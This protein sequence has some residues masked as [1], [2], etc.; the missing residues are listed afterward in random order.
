M[1][2]DPPMTTLQHLRSLLEQASPGPWEHKGFGFRVGF[3]HGFQDDAKPEQLDSGIYNA[4]LIA[5]MHAAIPSLLAVVEAAQA[6]IDVTDSSYEDHDGSAYRRREAVGDAEREL[7]RALDAL[8][9][10]DAT[11]GES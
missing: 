6:F 2:Q 4:E 8:T 3:C 11:E 9:S 1:S 10:I 5:A 7:R